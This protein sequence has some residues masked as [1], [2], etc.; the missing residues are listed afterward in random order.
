[1][2]PRKRVSFSKHLYV[3]RQGKILT[4]L[5]VY[6]LL[7]QALWSRLALPI[8]GSRDIVLSVLLSYN[9]YFYYYCYYDD[10]DD[11]Y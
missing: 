7:G 3:Q 5:G 10:D 8:L 9:H 1:M 2:T 4:G 11:Y 6:L